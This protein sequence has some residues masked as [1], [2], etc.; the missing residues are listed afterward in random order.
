[1]QKEYKIRHDWE[2]KV[3]HF[4]LCKWLCW[5]MVMAQTRIITKMSSPVWVNQWTKRYFFT[6]KTIRGK[7]RT[8]HRWCEHGHKG[9]NIKRETESLLTAA[10]NNAMR[11]S[12]NW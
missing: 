6:L 9:G 7:P 3:I 11:I 8:L 10:Q 4:E 2:G 12:N 5:Q 1:M